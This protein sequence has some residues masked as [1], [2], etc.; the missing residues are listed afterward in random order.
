[1]T[2]KTLLNIKIASLWRLNM[3][4]PYVPVN[5]IEC[6]CSELKTSLKS[7]VGHRHWRLQL[8]PFWLLSAECGRCG[9]TETQEN[10]CPESLYSFTLIWVSREPWCRW[11]VIKG[12]QGFKRRPTNPSWQLNW[13]PWTTKCSVR[14]WSR[15]KSEVW[16]TAGIQVLKYK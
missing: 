8:I 9:Q 10:G 11:M 14:P 6:F 7:K 13:C 5:L 12:P 15:H 3:T 16:V 1:M 4:C 2:Q